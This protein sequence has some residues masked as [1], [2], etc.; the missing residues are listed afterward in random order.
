M[1][2]CQCVGRSHLYENGVLE[3]TTSTAG[4]VKG[5]EGGFCGERLTKQIKTG[6]LEPREKNL[7]WWLGFE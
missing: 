4:T 2:V 7:V 1:T 6:V 5:S 3:N